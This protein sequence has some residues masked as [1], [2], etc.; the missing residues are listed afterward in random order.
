[1]RRVR[2]HIDRTNDL[3]G[4]AALGK[5]HRVARQR[6]RVT[7]DVHNRLW[8]EFEHAPDCFWRQACA[9]W[10]NHDEVWH[11]RTRL[12]QWL[13]CLRNVARNKLGVFDVVALR[14]LGCLLDSILD[15]L[16]PHHAS[17]V[18]RQCQPDGA[19]PAVEIP[20]R[21]RPRQTRLLDGDAV[22]LLAHRRV[23][24]EKTVMR[25][26]ER[27]AEDLLAIPILTG[28]DLGRVSLRRLGEATVLRL[29]QA[30]K[31]R[32]GL[33]ELINQVAELR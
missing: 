15:D 18:A 10:V 11:R 24:L 14:V 16:D 5:E 23:R 9:R 19:D 1:M 17:G 12:D 25:H 3:E 7:G 28:D 8:L 20:D 27:E 29:Q 13:D 6:C 22:K 32:H 21:F 31:T 30:D 33:L 26:V 4:V 2:E